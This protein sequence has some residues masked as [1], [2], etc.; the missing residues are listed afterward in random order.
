MKSNTLISFIFDSMLYD[1]KFLYNAF[2]FENILNI[3]FKKMLFDSHRN[4]YNSFSTTKKLEIF[5][6]L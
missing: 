5:V 1:N 2:N 3:G 6:D 4:I